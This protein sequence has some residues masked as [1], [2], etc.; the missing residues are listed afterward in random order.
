MHPIGHPPSHP[1]WLTHQ[2]ISVEEE[3]LLQPTLSHTLLLTHPLTTPS[4][5]LWLTH[6]GISVEEE[7]LLRFS[8]KEAVYKAIHPFLERSVDFSEVE[9]EP[10]QD[11]SAKIN[12]LL[13]TGT[14]I[15]Q[16]LHSFL[17]SYCIN[18]F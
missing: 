14:A 12:F 7:V 8:F 3:V 4:H 1:L 17:S 9:I 13:K 2:G 5:P 18:I 16:P 11:G 15:M 10:L 6:L